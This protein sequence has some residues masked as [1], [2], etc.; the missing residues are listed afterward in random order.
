M[1]L[2]SGILGNATT[3]SNDAIAK[4]LA[5]V[6]IINEEVDLS[7]KLIRDLIVFTNKRLIIIDKQ[8]MTGKKVEYR[9]IPYKSISR[10]SVETTGHFDLESELKIWISSGELPA[11]Q[12]MFRKDANII[13]VQKALATAIL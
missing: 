10:F 4:E 1:G 5:D 8:G 2:F 12:L 13:N 6:L 9:S 11:E 3:Q 7:F